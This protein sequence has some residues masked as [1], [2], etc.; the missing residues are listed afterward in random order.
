MKCRHTWYFL[1][2]HSLHCI[3][4]LHFTNIIIISHYI[5]NSSETGYI[6]S[7]CY[8]SVSLHMPSN[9]QHWQFIVL[10][11]W[12]NQWITMPSWYSPTHTTYHKPSVSTA[13]APVVPPARLGKN[14]T[15]SHWGRL[16]AIPFIILSP[17]T[18]PLCPHPTTAI[19]S[20]W[21]A[22]VRQSIHE[23]APWGHG[24]VFTPLN[25]PWLNKGGHLWPW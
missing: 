10:V 9:R 12:T 2:Q 25:P 6:C 13:S 14:P 17:L 22:V 18:Q 8:I 1:S 24:S 15:S 11:I 21:G 3:Y 4:Q 19:M 16:W 5:V 7:H 20:V 23:R